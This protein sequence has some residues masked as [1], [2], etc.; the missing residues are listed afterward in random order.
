MAVEIKLPKI[1]WG[2]KEPKPIKTEMPGRVRLRMRN[3][4]FAKAFF[5]TPNAIR[6]FALKDCGDYWE[7]IYEQG[8]NFR[9]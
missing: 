6:C 3:K 5:K 4:A 9:P 2:V 8:M 7:P 1:V